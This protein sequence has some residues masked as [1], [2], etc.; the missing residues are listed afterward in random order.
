MG[1]LLELIPHLLG[2]RFDLLNE[3]C[4]LRGMLDQRLRI[5]DDRVEQE[6]RSALGRKQRQR[7]SSTAL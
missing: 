3:A 5:E 2:G 1:Q 4:D 6:G 7:A